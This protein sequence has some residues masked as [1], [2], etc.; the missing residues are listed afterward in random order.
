MSDYW[1]P[2]YKNCLLKKKKNLYTKFF[3]HHNS[4]VLLEYFDEQ[5]TTSVCPRENRL[6]LYFF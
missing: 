4:K 1:E 6:S 3:T 5:Q 2:I